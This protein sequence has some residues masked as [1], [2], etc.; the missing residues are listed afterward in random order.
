MPSS[1]NDAEKPTG[2]VRRWELWVS[3]VMFAAMSAVQQDIVPEGMWSKI[4]MWIAGVLAQVGIIF[5]KPLLI[6]G[7][8]QPA[9][10]ALEKAEGENNVH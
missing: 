4:I 2:V 10:P 8:N 9:A 1:D 7:A 5:G 6:R 3:V